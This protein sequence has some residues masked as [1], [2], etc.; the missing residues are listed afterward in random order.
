MSAWPSRA[1]S[2]DTYH[3][4]LPRLANIATATAIATT[5]AKA[6]P[7]I[8]I[9]LATVLGTRACPPAGPPDSPAAGRT[10]APPGSRET[11]RPTGA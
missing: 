1:H 3:S 4:G 10:C 7:A 5:A 11:H 2:Q 6:I 8:N 9:M